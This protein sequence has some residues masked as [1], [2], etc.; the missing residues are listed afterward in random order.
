MKKPSLFK[1][2]AGRLAAE[3]RRYFNAI[4]Q[5]PPLFNTIAARVAEWRRR[6]ILQHNGIRFKRAAPPS[7]PAQ[8]DG[9]TVILNAY[10]RSGYMVQQIEAIRQ[11]TVRPALIWIWSNYAGAATEDFSDIA[12]RVIVSNYNWKFFG[13]FS[14]ANLAQTEF[15][16]LFDDDILPQPM[17]FENCLQTI[18]NGHDGIL[19]GSGLLLPQFG[20]YQKHKKIGW[21]GEHLE[22]VKEA[23]L[24][25]HAWFFRKTHLRHMWREDPYS[26]ENGED[27]HLSCMAKKYGGIKTLVPPHPPDTMQQWSCDA[28]FGKIAGGGQTASYKKRGHMALRNKA[29][30]YYRK[31]GWEICC[32]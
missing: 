3:W 1:E 23:D 26:W 19:G 20:S 7:I 31:N 2:I 25:G 27:I 9:I 11:Q 30:D 5:Q 18:N 6:K 32:Q 10:E 15:I 16:A 21:N 17:W 8:K 24:V 22:T 4:M 12:D 29:V 28:K 14:L 13:R